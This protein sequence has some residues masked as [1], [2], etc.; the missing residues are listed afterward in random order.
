MSQPESAIPRNPR[1]STSIQH[2]LA[3]MQCFTADAQLRGIADL[4]NL[5]GLNRSTTHR[6]AVTLVALR[7]LEQTPSRKYFLAPSAARP[8]MAVLGEIALRTNC[9]PVLQAL[10][11]QTR[12]TVGLTVLDGTRVTYVRRLSA[13]LRGQYAADMDLRAGAHLPIHCTAAGKA[14]LASLPP[15]RC[16]ELVGRIELVARGPNAI[17]AKPAL[18]RQVEQIR[19]QGLALS[20]EEYAAGVRSVAAAVEDPSGGRQLAVNV[21]VP[22]DAYTIAQLQAQ[23]GPLVKVAA[24]TISS[25]LGGSRDIA[26]AD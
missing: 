9:E 20:D 7:F 5:L 10:R 3:M 26:A 24:Q 21:N 12:H 14:L 22:A 25:Q 18:L 19:Q 8:G 15:E 1:F 16:R 23:L 17:R 6:Y 13:H 4:S 11:E 2:G